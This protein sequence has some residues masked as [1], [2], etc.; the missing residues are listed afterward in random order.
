[1]DVSGHVSCCLVYES[2]FNVSVCC[3]YLRI[4]MIKLNQI[5]GLYASI[6]ET[7]MSVHAMGDEIDG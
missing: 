2:F 7:Y 3:V 6:G 1:M 5:L 4:K